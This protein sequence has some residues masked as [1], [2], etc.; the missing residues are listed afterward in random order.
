MADTR[1]S[2]DAVSRKLASLRERET[3]QET[4]AASGFVDPA[5]SW[6]LRN[7][8]LDT[9]DQEGPSVILNSRR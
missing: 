7:S 6:M 5:L 3:L 9:V 2:R 8:E 4:G 1:L